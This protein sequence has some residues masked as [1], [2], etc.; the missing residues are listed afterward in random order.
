MKSIFRTI[1]A[2]AMLLMTV[3]C[4]KILE[5]LYIGITNTTWSY[6]LDD[7]RAFIRF[8]TDDRVTIVQRN[9]GNGA[10]QFNNGTYSVDG[11]AVDILSDEGA[12]NRLVRTFSHLKNSSN[13][14][15]STYKPQEYTSMDYSVWTSLRKDV[16]RVIY[17]TPDGKT[18]QASF[19]NVIHEEGVP[20]GWEQ[21]E[22]TFTLSGSH[23]D[24]GKESAILFDEVMLVDDVWF[25]HFPVNENKGNSDLTGTMWTYHTSSYP[26]IIIFDTNSSFTRILLSSRILYQ[27]NRGTYVQTGDVV[28]MTLNGKTE[29]CLIEGNSFTYLERT[30]DLYQ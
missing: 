15:F 18:K 10:V 26:G 28:T 17:F 16:F 3:S 9:N 30:Y 21:G 7:Q 25:M 29:D 14:N 22:T 8:G 24:M 13:K 2:L 6:T 1:V 27:V 11:H 12:S 23:L 19:K 4:S 20:Y 5:P